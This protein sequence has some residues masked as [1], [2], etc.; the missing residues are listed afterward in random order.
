MGKTKSKEWK[1]N[2]LWKIVEYALLVIS[3]IFFIVV[4]V[5]NPTTTENGALDSYMFWN[6]FLVIAG[7]ILALAF[8]LVK[9][10]KSKKSLRN[11]L[12]LIVAAVVI[13]GGAWLLAPGKEIAVNTETTATTFKFAD[14]CLNVCYVFIFGS[15]AAL[16]GSA[17]FKAVRK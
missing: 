3:L 7:I 13:I 16:I 11:L 8:P 9:S 4:F 14:A 2:G 5:A 6:Y 12:L 1:E 17:I 10:F 15:I